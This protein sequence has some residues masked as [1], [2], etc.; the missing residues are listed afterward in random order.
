MWK[1]KRKYYSFI[2]K[3]WFGEGRTSIDVSEK[4]ENKIRRILSKVERVVRHG[5]TM[6]FM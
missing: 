2:I 4:V 6:T 3:R 1:M 5:T